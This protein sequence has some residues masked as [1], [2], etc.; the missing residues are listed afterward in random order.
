MDQQPAREDMQH[1]FFLNV[2]RN[3]F[4]LSSTDTNEAHGKLCLSFLVLSDIWVICW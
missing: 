2:F 4:L 3:V 1:V